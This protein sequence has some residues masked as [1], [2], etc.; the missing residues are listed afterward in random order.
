MSVLVRTLPFDR[1]E[2]L[3][4]GPKRGERLEVLL[5]LGPDRCSHPFLTLAEALE[6]QLAVVHET[7]KIDELE[8]QNR[9]P[10][11]DLLILAG[12]VVRGGRQ[13]RS[14]GVDFVVPANGPRLR[15]PAFCVEAHRWGARLGED[16]AGFSSSASM[17]AKEL[18]QGVRREKSQF[19][20][21]RSVER[22]HSRL[23]SALEVDVAAPA[24]RSS[25]QLMMEHRTLLERQAAFR[26]QCAELVDS[27]P[28]TIGFVFTVDGVPSS[29][30]LFASFHLA[31]AY[32][33]KLVDAALVTALTE[34]PR[35]KRAEAGP[36]GPDAIRQ[37][38]SPALRGSWPGTMD[39]PPLRV[40]QCEYGKPPHRTAF[41][42]SLDVQRGIYLHRSWSRISRMAGPA[43]WPWM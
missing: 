17:L 6:R 35:G 36:F 25:Y 7:G 1:I 16:S 27:H 32:S 23:S 14:L 26:Q 5:L 41:F 29:A 13:D 4:S 38:L 8:I 20:V 42:A 18:M 39:V 2:S 43:R 31:R 22:V 10:D 11:R 33:A 30:D 37:W 34:V 28:T 12:E 21:W 9:S 3:P 40:E 15:I 19:A 24:S